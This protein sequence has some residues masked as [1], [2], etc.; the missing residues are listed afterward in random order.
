MAQ[1]GNMDD[2]GNWENIWGKWD[3]YVKCDT[4]NIRKNE[5]LWGIR[6]I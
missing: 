1:T 4:G 2:T 6:E 3:M 5:R